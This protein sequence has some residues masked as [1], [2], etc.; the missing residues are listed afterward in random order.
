MKILVIG[1]GGR[2]H[3][4]CWK[5]SQSKQVSKIFCAPGNA[6]TSTVA[7]N[8]PIPY[9]DISA[10]LEFALK[11]KIDLTIVGPETPLVEGVVDAF[12]EKGMRIFGPSGTAAM[13]EG[14]KAFA[15]EIMTA[16]KVPTARYEVIA[17]IDEAQSIV[18]EFP[19]GAAVKA[20]GL[21]QG[22][23]VIICHSQSEI[24][25]AVNKL[26]QES[27]FGDAGKRIV[28]EE[29]LDGEEASILAFCDGKT[30]KLMV[31][32]QDH[33]RIFD[34]DKGE[35]TGGMGAYAPAPVVKGLEEKIHGAVFVPVL[36]EMQKRG[37]PYKGV[38]YAG[39]MIKG[40]EFKVIEF[41]ARFGDPETQPTLSLLETD[42][43]DIV[44]SCIDGK[45]GKTEIKWKNGAAC[46]VVIASKGYP[47]K[48]EKG[49]AISGLD[50]AAKLKDVVVFHAG[51]RPEGGK[52]LT[53]G[54]RVLGV[55]GTG[56]SIKDAIANAYTGVSK[57]K[58]DGMQFRKDIG[59]RAL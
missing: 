8:V 2:E 4:L 15:K 12:E 13:L 35:N 38:L 50:A 24:M 7:E 11:N 31:S 6:G 41:N 9:E 59:K 21:A 48:Y 57:I 43:V 14:S 1:S 17:N 34:G 29:L 53:N 27:I 36:N 20:D 5:L 23:G 28:I 58:F 47:E 30:A 3:A 52:A 22:K 40:K 26:M 18:D 10:L 42:L 44:N 46:C 39:L 56:A 33:K 51:T 49:H 55:T 16:A 19:R 54:G 45:L 32:S 25:G 37:T